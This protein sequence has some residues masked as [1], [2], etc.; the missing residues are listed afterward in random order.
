MTTV[1]VP[2]PAMPAICATCP[3]YF[4]PRGECRAT[5]PT[6]VLHA[7]ERF[8]PLIGEDGKPILDANGQP[9]DG[10]T[11][12]IGPKQPTSFFPPQRPD[13]WCG[14]HPMRRDGQRFEELMMKPQI[15][16]DIIKGITG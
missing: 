7:N 5:I 1:E 8:E 12:V 11:K 13:S 14:H 6:G 9:V 15:P 2:A 16:P 4:A 10:I 3:F